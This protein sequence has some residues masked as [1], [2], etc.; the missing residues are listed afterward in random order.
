MKGTLEERFWAKVEKRGP[1]DCWIFKG[2]GRYPG[3]Y[4]LLKFNSA[5]LSAHRVSWEI[6]NNMKIPDG[7]IILHKCDNPPCVNPAHLAT[8]TRK[9]NAVDMVLKGRNHT[10][11]GEANPNS[12]LRESEVLKVRELYKLGMNYKALAAKFNVP[13]MCIYYIV[14][15]KT[16]KH[17]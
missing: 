15:R 7:L 16:W 12:L 5:R 3:D 11:L 8:G 6:A 17:I 13:Y 10:S 1:D 4:G 9:Q 14:R 2:K